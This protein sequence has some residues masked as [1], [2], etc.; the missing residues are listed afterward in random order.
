MG[1]LRRGSED[2][3]EVE[4]AIAGYLASSGSHTRTQE[5]Q[6]FVDF[7]RESLARD[8]TN[9]A[10]DADATV[11]NPP[12]EHAVPSSQYLRGFR[13]GSDVAADFESLQSYFFQRTRRFPPAAKAPRTFSAPTSPSPFSQG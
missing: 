3:D 4:D 2:E 12:H 13:Q 1:A 10:F 9:E 11:G 8:F 5:L 6:E 7:L